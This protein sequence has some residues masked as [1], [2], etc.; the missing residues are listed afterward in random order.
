MEKSLFIGTPCYGG[1]AHVPFISA[2]ISTCTRLP[3][4]KH[5]RFV[6][7][8]LVTRA[9][10]NIAAEFLRSDYTHLLFIDADIDFRAE[11]VTALLE[12]DREIVCGLY[13]KKVFG[14]PQWVINTLPGEQKQYEDGP[15]SEVKYAGTGF[16][17][18][19]RNALE[20]II[21]AHPELH[22]LAD[23]DESGEGARDRWD[24]FGDPVID[25]RKLSEDWYF[26]HLWREL[27]GKIWVD[28][29]VHLGHIGQ[30]R[31]PTVDESTFAA[32]LERAAA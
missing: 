22:Y 19:A 28:R 15:L 10:N 32:E 17:L 21:A 2:L 11:H 20:K 1:V 31:F 8:S 13:P 14:D 16:M 23:T 26:C 3:G 29:R 5:V 6:Q 9:R 27:G 7:D 4:R 18:I 25:G 24:I 12:H 30:L